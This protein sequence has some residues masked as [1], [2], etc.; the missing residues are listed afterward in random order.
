MRPST[1]GVAIVP[2][3]RGAA[4][5]PSE[6]DRVKAGG[7]AT[8]IAAAGFLTYFAFGYASVRNGWFAFDLDAATPL[9]LVMIASNLALA[10]TARTW[11][12]ARWF[13]YV[14]EV[15][16]AVALTVLLHWFGGVAMGLLF[17]T[18][19]LRVAN[20]EILRPDAPAFVT[21]N[22]CAGCYA[23]LAF[24]EAWGWWT[25]PPVVPPLRDGQYLACAIAGFL[26]LN[27]LALYA[28]RYAHQLRTFAAHLQGKVAERTAELTE[29]NLELARAYDD[30]RTAETELLETEKRAALGLLVSGVAHEINNP[31]SF[32]VGNM[33]PLR[34]SLAML[35]D[36]ADRQQD[37]ELFA[38]VGRISRT[39][40]IIGRGAE[41]TAAIVRDLRLFLRTGDCTAEPLDVHDSL[42]ITL[43]LLSPHWADRVTIHR[44]YGVVPRIEA[45]AAQLNK[46]FMSVLINA[47]EAIS[48]RGNIW[49]STRSEPGYAI[50]GIRDDGAGIASDVLP[51]IFNP[52]F[53]TKGI[54]KGTGLGLAITHSIVDDHGGTILVS[55]TCGQGTIFTIAMPVSKRATAGLRPPARLERASRALRAVRAMRQRA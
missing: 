48:G 20:S 3:D 31:V 14:Y 23:T 44:D 9:F 5:A 16:H 49:I 22:L 30:L 34:T 1:S 35:A 21:A 11:A 17:I 8:L 6:F 50:V 40:D 53:R 12:S 32:I 54:G 15:A 36:V 47:C 55:S 45:A 52:F 43:R 7:T 4:A 24:V 38:I 19:A 41:R 25:P 13:F 2:A 26:P 27:I 33:E 51:R 37:R 42:E 29:A 10:A 18:Y 39:T 46:V 28:S